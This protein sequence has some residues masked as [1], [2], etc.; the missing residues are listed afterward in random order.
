[1]E[2]LHEIYIYLKVSKQS[3]CQTFIC[4]DIYV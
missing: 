3:I 2:A 4:D 1:M